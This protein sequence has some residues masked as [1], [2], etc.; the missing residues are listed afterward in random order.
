MLLILIWLTY[1]IFPSHHF[2][3]HMLL[4]IPLVALLVL[5]WLK[6]HLWPSLSRREHAP[7]FTDAR[8]GKALGIFAAVVG[9]RSLFGNGKHRG[10]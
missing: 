2:V 8:E 4:L 7:G 1:S 10:F 6:P 5:A 3:A 9:A